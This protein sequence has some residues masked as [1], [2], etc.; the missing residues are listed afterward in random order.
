MTWET[1]SLKNHTRNVVEELFSD[2]F[3]KNQNWVHLRI[4][5]LN[6]YKV[7]FYCVLIWGLLIYSETKLHTT[8]FYLIWSFF[9]KTKSGL[10]LVSLPNFLDNFW[11]KIFLLLYSI[12]WPNF[13]AWLPLICEILSIVYYNCLLTRLWRRE[14]RN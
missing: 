8:C 7:C 11:R 12:N 5:S 4:N 13:I 10:E 6:F 2:P 14:F 9:K 1:F 3:S